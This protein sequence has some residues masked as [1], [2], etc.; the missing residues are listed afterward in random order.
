MQSEHP[1]SLYLENH[2]PAVIGSDDPG[3]LRGD[4]S[5]EY[6]KLVRRYPFVSYSMVKDMIRNSIKYSFIKSPRMK[7]DILK[8][9]ERRFTTFEAMIKKQQRTPFLV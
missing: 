6:V 9:L 1:I 3:I 5:E 7:Q 2:V 8:G 4:I